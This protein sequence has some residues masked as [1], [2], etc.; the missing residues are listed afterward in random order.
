MDEKRNLILIIEDHE[1]TRRALEG[2]LNREGWGVDSAATVAEGLRLLERQPRCVV[3]DLML[4]DARGE[5]VLRRVKEAHSQT[6]VIVTTGVADQQELAAVAAL[7]PDAVL[8]KP[9]EMNMFLRICRS[10]SQGR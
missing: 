1:P 3:L 4:P 5:D 6:R 2:V 10:I 9:I 7:A 8:S